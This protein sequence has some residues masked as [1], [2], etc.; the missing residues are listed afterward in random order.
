MFGSGG[1][2]PGW[3]VGFSPHVVAGAGLRHILNVKFKLLTP[4]L[5]T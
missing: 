1:L 3:L 2:S 4:S 5:R